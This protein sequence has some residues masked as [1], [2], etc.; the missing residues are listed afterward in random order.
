MDLSIVIPVYNGQDC[1]R[2]SLDSI[3]S[4][5]M[6]SQSLEVIVVD[7]CSTD[8]TRAVLEDYAGRYE[9]IDYICLPVNKKPGG[10]RNAGIRQ[11]KGKYIMFLDSDDT[12]EQG[13]PEALSYAMD[14]GVDMLL[15]HRYDQRTFKGSFKDVRID[16]PW[17]Q[18][19]SG[20]VFLD[21]FYVVDTMGSCSSYLYKRSFLDGLGHPFEEGLYF[22][23]VDWVEHV[24]FFCPVIEYD[25]SIIF[26]YYSNPGSVLHTMNITK[27]A[28]VVL[29]CCRRMAF[30][31]SVRDD[32]P[33]F[34]KNS[35]SHQGWI[36]SIIKF[37]HLTT[38]DRQSVQFFY[39]RIRERQGFSW[40]R[41]LEWNG[42]AK[43]FVFHPKLALA[44]IDLCRPPL[45]AGRGLVQ[46]IRKR[47]NRQR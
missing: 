36:A 46:S 35:L 38:F 13:L 39:N 37:R 28:D 20:R 45:R 7:D 34:Y 2:R 33:R 32:A 43:L 15:C 23:D 19:F 18:P 8:N 5:H 29:Y 22:E 10:A 21:K 41:Q 24:L 27:E 12:A 31:Y 25:T 17:H 3:L 44:L 14:Q 42:F 30:A 47:R 40:L 6:P 9:Q 16:M 26:S 4:L 1:I 11:A